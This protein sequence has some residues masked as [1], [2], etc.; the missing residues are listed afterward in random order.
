[1]CHRFAWDQVG[2]PCTMVCVVPCTRMFGQ[3]DE[4]GAETP[5]QHPWQS[6]LLWYGSVSAR[7][8][9]VLKIDSSS[10]TQFLIPTKMV[11]YE[12]FS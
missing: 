5:S 8:G 4:S 11:L 3:G 7:K 6:Y 9:P 12:F 10:R 1:M 2:P